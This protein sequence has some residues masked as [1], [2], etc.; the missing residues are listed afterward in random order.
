MKVEGQPDHPK[1]ILI[2]HREDIRQN[3]TAKLSLIFFLHQ[4]LFDYRTLSYMAKY[5]FSF[6]WTILIL[7]IHYFFLL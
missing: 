7:S 6:L 5:V 2:E 1:A 3:K 4:A